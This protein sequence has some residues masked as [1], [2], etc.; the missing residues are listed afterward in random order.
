MCL[1]SSYCRKKRRKS[2]AG[3]FSV[4][5]IETH[6]SLLVILKCCNE[7]DTLSSIALWSPLSPIFQDPNWETLPLSWMLLWPMYFMAFYQVVINVLVEDKTLEPNHLIQSSEQSS[8]ECSSQVQDLSLN[9]LFWLQHRLLISGWL[10]GFSGMTGTKWETLS[11]FQYL[12]RWVILN[13][14]LWKQIK[15]L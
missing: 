15:Q 11:S 13:K 4:N 7:T 12:Q 10:S 14:P 1:V 2:C 5:S 6:C 9:V 3:E 8:P